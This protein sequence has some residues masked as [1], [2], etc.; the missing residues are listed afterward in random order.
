[1]KMTQENQKALKAP[2]GRHTSTMRNADGK[3]NLQ[4]PKSPESPERA[5]HVNHGQRPW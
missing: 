2:K 4:K 5:P 1:M 3:Q